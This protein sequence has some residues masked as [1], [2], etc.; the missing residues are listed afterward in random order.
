MTRLYSAVRKEITY[1]RRRSPAGFLIVVVIVAFAFVSFF[2][3]HSHTRSREHLIEMLKKENKKIHG[4]IKEM[5]ENEEL[6]NQKPPH[7]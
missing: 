7:Y 4:K 2:M 1:G 3:M 5:L 6:L